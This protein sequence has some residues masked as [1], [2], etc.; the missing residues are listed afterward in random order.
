M[1]YV[2]FIQAGITGPIKIG[3]SKNP[4]GRLTEIQINHYE[5]LTLLGFVAHTEMLEHQIHNAVKGHRIR[6]EWF[7]PAK[8]ILD[9]IE[10]ITIATNISLTVKALPEMVERIRASDLDVILEQQTAD[11]SK[12]K[13]LILAAL[14]TCGGNIDKTAALLGCARRTVQNRMQRLGIPRGK[15]GRPPKQLGS[16]GIARRIAPGRHGST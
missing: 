11:E 5:T 16:G 3:N 15:A 2:Y 1:T 14:R 10:Q 8:E 9:L 12:E 4:R 13:E 6:G 7:S